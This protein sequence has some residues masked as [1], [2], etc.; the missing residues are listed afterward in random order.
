MNFIKRIDDLG[1]IVIPKEIRRIL[2]IQNNEDMEINLK[3]EEIIL[4]KHNILKEKEKV[5]ITMCNL[6]SDISSKKIIV[7]DREKVFYSNIES[8]I[9]KEISDKLKDS[10]INRK[11]L[12]LGINITDNYK[13]ESNYIYKELIIDSNQIGILL[14]IDE[15]LDE[16]DKL[17]LEIVSKFINTI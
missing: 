15:E 14:I 11:E 2:N 5:I 9:N 6:I 10:I 4:K 7:T 8:I 16:K 1:R 3:E 12:E 13:I 17:L